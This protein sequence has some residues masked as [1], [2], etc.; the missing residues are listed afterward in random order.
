MEPSNARASLVVSGLDLT[1]DA[2]TLAAQDHRYTELLRQQTLEMEAAASRSKLKTRRL[3]ELCGQVTHGVR[4][5]DAWLARFEKCSR[6]PM[7]KQVS[8]EAIRAAHFK[9]EYRG[10]TSLAKY[11]DLLEFPEEHLALNSD[12]IKRA[13]ILM[14]L[15]NRHHEMMH[16]FIMKRIV[17]QQTLAMRHLTVRNPRPFEARSTVPIAGA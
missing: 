1:S 11:V 17:P 13:D 14:A 10:C 8:E 5:S 6:S 15:C 4:R 16:G 2:A 9:C 3:L 12:W 7:W